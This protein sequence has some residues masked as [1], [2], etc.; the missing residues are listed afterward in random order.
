MRA[1]VQKRVRITGQMF[2]APPTHRDFASL[3]SQHD[4]NGVGRIA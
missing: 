1:P 3:R 4:I 2:R